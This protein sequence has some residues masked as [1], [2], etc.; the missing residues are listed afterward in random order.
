MPLPLPYSGTY[1]SASEVLMGSPFNNIYLKNLSLCIIQLCFYFIFF[2]ASSSAT[3]YLTD[4]RLYYTLT[5]ERIQT[6]THKE[7][8]FTFY[9]HRSTNEKN[10]ERR[11]ITIYSQLLNLFV[12]EI[13]IV[14]SSTAHTYFMI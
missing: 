10:M 3:S 6:Q 1:T 14:Q 8:T 9:S 12:S 11:P 7:K 2:S 4:N 13:Q 5:I